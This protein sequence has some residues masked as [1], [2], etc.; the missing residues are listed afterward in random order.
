MNYYER[1]CGDYAKK[2]ARLTLVQHGAYTLLLDE[3]YSTEQPLSDD[4]EELYRVCRAMSKA[5]QDAVRFVAD[6]FFPIGPDG[7]RHNERADEMIAKARPK[8][9]AAKANGK[10]GGR[11]RKNPEGSGNGNPDET[12]AKPSGKPTGFSN[13]NPEET[14]V[15]TTRARSPTP[16]PEEPTEAKASDADASPDP[17][18]VIWKL[19]VQLLKGAGDSEANARSFLG[20]H[21][22][23]DETK[24]AEVIGHLAANPKIEPKAYIVAAMAPEKPELAF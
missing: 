8:M 19:G 22:K 7:L 17:K 14:Q 1:Y 9:E 15:E 2:T 23:G 20:K 18:S 6:R 21:A 5:E 3:Y 12:Q 16:T 13:Q 4:F 10:K 24:L 11:P